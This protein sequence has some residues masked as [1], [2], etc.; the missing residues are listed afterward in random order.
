M[1]VL[2]NNTSGLLALTALMS[3]LLTNACGGAPAYK[4]HNHL[5]GLGSRDSLSVLGTGF[6]DVSDNDG[7]VSVLDENFYAAKPEE[8]V[9]SEVRRALPADAQ[10]VVREVLPTCGRVL[11]S[12]ASLANQAKFSHG[13]GGLVGALVTLISGDKDKDTTYD[14]TA[15]TYVTVNA[16]TEL[17]QDLSGPC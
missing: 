9:L 17:D 10:L 15:V 16:V 12:S 2:G 3:L 8:A 6:D 7:M 1:K 13:G 4:A 5:V 14:K 11:Y